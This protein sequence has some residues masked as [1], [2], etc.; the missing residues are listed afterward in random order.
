[1][2]LPSLVWNLDPQGPDVSLVLIKD[3]HA[4]LVELEYTLVLEASALEDWG[5]KSL[6]RYNIEV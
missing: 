1:M 6:T 4:A 5:C 2:E 3:T